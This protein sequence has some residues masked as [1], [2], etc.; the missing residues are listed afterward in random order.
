MIAANVMGYMLRFDN[1]FWLYTFAV[2]NLPFYSMEV[3]HLMLKKFHMV[4]GEL[5]PVEGKL[6]SY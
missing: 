5:G 2:V 6:K 4:V 3:K 1:S